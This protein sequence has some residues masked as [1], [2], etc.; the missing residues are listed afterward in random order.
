MT[1]LSVGK[2]LTANLISGTT[3]L[4]GNLN[5]MNLNVSVVSASNI[6]LSGTTTIQANTITLQGGVVNIS[7]T[8]FDISGEFVAVRPYIQMNY[9][10]ISFPTL[11]GIEFGDGGANIS[12]L[13]RNSV[14]PIG[15]GLLGLSTTNLYT[16]TLSV[17]Q[18]IGNQLDVTYFR[19]SNQ[20]NVGQ[21]GISAVSNRIN[22]D[23][24]GIS[25]Q[26]SSNVLSL[27]CS[28]ISCQRYSG[29]VLARGIRY[30]SADVQPWKLGYTVSVSEASFVVS[31]VSSGVY[32][33]GSI[34][35]AKGQY[36]TNL[37]I[38][39]AISTVVSTQFEA[40]LGF[41]DGV[42][43]NPGAFLGPSNYVT[44]R[45]GL[46]ALP[47]V[48]NYQSYILVMSNSGTKYLNMQYNTLAIS[49]QYKAYAEL[50]RIA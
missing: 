19:T 1:T 4:V 46:A 40:L 49:Q 45:I 21:I 23:M 2:T 42:L 30:I 39:H 33:F 44:P 3:L 41:V 13:S 14:D 50:T 32:N 48:N 34:S 18:I 29:D 37:A 38:Y 43:S 16:T 26:I 36:I 25:M 11:G 20:T 31:S 35:L 12:A 47:V 22:I 8:N 10:A 28:E 9:G 5:V 15:W 24:S 17:Q 7:A 27:N 6:I